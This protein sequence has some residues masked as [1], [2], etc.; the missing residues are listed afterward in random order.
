MTG[1]R[2]EGM[3]MLYLVGSLD[4]LP[5]DPVQ[6]PITA[7]PP[8]PLCTC[9]SISCATRLRAPL[10]PSPAVLPPIAAP[11]LNLYQTVLYQ[12][13]TGCYIPEDGFLHSDRCENLKS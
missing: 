2:V 9:R 8:R 1:G 7:P 13:R 3:R 12:V 5:R 4:V 6:L 11:H 10:T